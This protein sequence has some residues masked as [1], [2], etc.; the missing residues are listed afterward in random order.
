MGWWM[1]LTDGALQ[2]ETNDRFLFATATSSNVITLDS[3]QAESVFNLEQTDIVNG[4]WDSKSL[5]SW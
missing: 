4:D 2:Q 5:K 3:H 1:C